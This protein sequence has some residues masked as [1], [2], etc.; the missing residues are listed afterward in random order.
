MPSFSALPALAL[1]LPGELT[2]LSVARAL[3]ARLDHA[4]PITRSVLNAELSAA[5]SGS[6]AAGRWSV[7]DVHAALELA[8]VI[9][10]QGRA[11]ID[12]RTPPSQAAQLFDQLETLLPRQTV[13][14]DEQIELQQFATPPRIAWLA[15]RS[16]APTR[17]ELVLEPSAGTGMLAVW[18]AKAGSRLAF[19]EISGL[20]RPTS[21]P[22]IL[23]QRCSQ[24]AGQCLSR[25]A[26]RLC[27]GAASS[28]VHSVSNSPVGPPVGLTG[29]RFRAASPRS[30]GFRLGCSFRWKRP[31]Q[32]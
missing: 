22:M 9:W 8:Q 31:P 28:M 1:P 6:D 17:S 4:E 10:L 3:A 12:L 30:S 15:A 11:D 21:S 14:S 2:V 7:R 23:W 16:C 26:R 32:C 25:A 5:F 20:Q 29:T 13:R 24:L 27:W 18:A 19:N